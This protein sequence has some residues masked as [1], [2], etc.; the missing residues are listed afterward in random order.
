MDLSITTV[1]CPVV[2]YL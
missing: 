2:S 1:T